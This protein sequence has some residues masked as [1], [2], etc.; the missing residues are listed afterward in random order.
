MAAVKPPLPGDEEVMLAAV[1]LI[2]SQAQ[3]PA[4]AT[5]QDQ[6]AAALVAS[7]EFLEKYSHGTEDTGAEALLALLAQLA[8]NAGGYLLASLLGL[9]LEPSV[10]NLLDHLDRFEHAIRVLSGSQPVMPPGSGVN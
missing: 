2:R 3:L 7:R 4:G 8:V 10:E 1:A 9:G 6:L 5:P